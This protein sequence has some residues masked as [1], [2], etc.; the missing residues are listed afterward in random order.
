MKLVPRIRGC[1]IA[2]ALIAAESKAEP[3]LVRSAA[4]G[5]WSE[6]ATWEG[7][8]LPTAG[9]RVQIRPGHLV[10]FDARIEAPIR[11]IHVAGTLEFD[12]DRDTLLTVG[13]IQVR[14][15]D[16]P[17]EA[18]LDVHGSTSL[19]P[20]EHGD[21][22][23]SLLVGTAARPIA[24]GR[25]ALIRLAQVE[26]LDPEVCPAILCQGG[27]MEF[28]GAPVNPTWTKLARP[29]GVG[30]ASV[31]LDRP[32]EGWRVGDR[33]IV[34]STRRQYHR[35]D[36]LIPTVR[37]APQTEE[38]TIKAVEGARV[39]LDSPLSRA[40]ASAGNFRGEVAL[41][42][43]NVV[44]ESAD[45]G[46]VRG[47][48]MYHRDS[49][50]SIS[51]AEFRHLGKPGQ[52]GKYSLHFHKAGDSMRGSSVVGASIWDSGNRWITIHGT[53]RLVVR[54]CVGYQ[55]LGHGFFLEDGTE[56]DNQFDGNLAVQS[57]AASP[58]PGQAL[59]FDHNEGAG[60]WWT[61]SRN[62]FSRNV[63]VECDGYGFRLDAP[64]SDDFNPVFK[65]RGADGRVAASDVRHQPF[66]R[67]D[68]NEAHS[69]RHYGVNLAGAPSGGDDPRA[70]AVGPDARH[71]LA[72]RGLL[73]WDCRWAFT[74]SSPGLM[75]EGLELS[76]SDYGFYRP[77]FDRQAYRGLKI[78]QCGKGYADMKGRPPEASSYPAPLEPVDDRAP[79]T[80]ITDARAVGPDRVRVEGCSADDGTI[81]SVRVNGVEARP[82]SPDFSRWEV[83]LGPVPA[84]PIAL[85]LTALAEDAAGT[86]EKSPHV[87]T[88]ATTPAN[89]PSP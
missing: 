79:V 82:L 59:A 80:V 33:V 40:H 7:G 84:P 30:E 16:D 60:F 25:S 15:G 24:A 62:A 14:G 78:Y 35:N 65:F 6:R 21:G 36:A 56:V 2:I 50:G 10:I 75:V 44:V 43:R 39:T 63:A 4:D 3:P 68:G 20:I 66:L 42:S 22:R 8:K 57:L 28:H 61:N 45:P 11:S 18:G 85:T 83:T 49:L 27:R 19:A 74:P 47:H 52:L 32:A 41:L 1:L 58:L 17:A 5:R 31:T 69:Q 26:G 88:L 9:D 76:K 87:L 48:T 37:Q 46:G 29:A 64:A 89:P 73:V 23:P 13:L 55:S 38:R 54:D 53:N 12:P 81:R 71:P 72:I 34:T 77:N 86:V 70:D 67:F 51:F